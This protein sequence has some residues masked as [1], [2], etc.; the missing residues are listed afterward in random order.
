MA[1][2]QQHFD[3]VISTQDTA[4]ELLDK[5]LPLPLLVTAE[6]QT[7]GRGR[8]GRQ[9]ISPRGNFFCSFA[10]NAAV[11]IVRYGEYSFLTAVV[12]RN[13]ISNFSDRNVSLK[14][15]NDILLDERK[16]AGI[17]I[18][19]YGSQNEFLIIG[20]GVNL[21]YAPTEDEVHQPAAALWPDKAPNPQRK[22]DFMR[23][24]VENFLLW[25][26]RY[27]KGGFEMIHAAWLKHAHNLAR[28]IT[29]QTPQGPQDGIFAGLDPHGNLL[30]TR[31]EETIKVTT[32]DV[33]I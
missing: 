8:Q 16:C 32:A 22:A 9:W 26:D 33:L 24:L 1:I 11:P 18:E 17:L 20:I 28:Q 10:I 4:R 29:V 23:Q 15:P 30:L 5:N 3:Q 19:S 21:R 12:L 25:H 7:S 2:N 13:T 27:E 6:E 14:W 31:G